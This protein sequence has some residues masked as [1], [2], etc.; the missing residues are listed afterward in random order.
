ME[1]EGEQGKGEEGEEEEMD[2]QQKVAEGDDGTSNE[3]M[4]E[5]GN[6]TATT[7][8]HGTRQWV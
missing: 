3:Q 5:D 7:E 8:A 6:G 4:D 1:E 2:S